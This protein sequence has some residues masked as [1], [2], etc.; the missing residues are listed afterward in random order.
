MSSLKA[1]NPQLQGAMDELAIQRAM[2]G[3]R[4][5]TLAGE[6]ARLTAENIGLRDELAQLKTP[7]ESH[8]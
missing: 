8:G 2:F 5:V 7:T 3:D 1:D 6:V 4:C